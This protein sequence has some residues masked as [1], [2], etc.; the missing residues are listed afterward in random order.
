MERIVLACD[1][2]TDSFFEKSIAASFI[3]L[4]GALEVLKDNDPA[5]PN[6]MRLIEVW[7]DSL[8]GLEK[9]EADSLRGQLDRMRNLSI[10]RGIGRIVARYLGQNKSREV[11]NLYDVRSHLVHD[12]TRPPNLEDCLQRTQLIVRE[13]LIKVLHQSAR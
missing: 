11:K 9:E 13:L 10:K 1:L 4:I 2:Y 3:T 12:G 7:K 5:S 6:A 8:D